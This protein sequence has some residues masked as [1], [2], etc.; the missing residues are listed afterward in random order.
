MHSNPNYAYVRGQVVP[1]DQAFLHISDLAI[2]RGYGVFDYFRVHNGRPVFLDDYLMRLQESAKALHMEV[3]LSDE[4]L[5]EVILDIISKNDIPVSGIK[6]I[7]TGGYSANGYDP[8]EPSLVILQQPMALPSSE[9][10]EKGIKIITHDYVRE[11]PRA[12]TINYTM[13]IRLIDEIRQQGAHDVLYERN[14][15]VTEFP[16]CNLFIV[17]HDDTVI[18]PAE[19]VLLGVTRKNVLAL[20]DQKYKA[21][22]GEVTVEDIY[23][24]KEVFLTSTTKRILPIVQVNDQVIGSGKPGAV[25]LD[26][27][28]ALI[29]LEEAYFSL[30]V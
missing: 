21:V 26:L 19:N 30:A 7:L 11:V 23:Q 6:M 17:K 29:K 3:P 9:L 12:K 4:E 2:Q 27:L 5:K 18:T 24:A 16:R 8:A 15:V 28:Q 25:T 13:G 1:L 22:E 14:G 10:V 20:A